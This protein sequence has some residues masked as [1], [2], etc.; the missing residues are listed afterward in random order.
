MH[1]RTEGVIMV[2]MTP[3]SREMGFMMETYLARSSSSGM[4]KFSMS[5]VEKKEKLMIS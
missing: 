4:R 2:L 5:F 3:Q 1:L